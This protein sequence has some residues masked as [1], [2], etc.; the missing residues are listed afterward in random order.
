MLI[1]GLVENPKRLSMKEIR[2]ELASLFFVNAYFELPR[3]KILFST[4]MLRG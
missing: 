4:E 3:M 1:S 2:L